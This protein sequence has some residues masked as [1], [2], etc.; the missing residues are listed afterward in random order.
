MG[1]TVWVLF[2]VYI[3]GFGISGVLFQLYGPADFSNI[4]TQGKYDVA[5]TE[6][7]TRVGENAVSV[8]YPADKRKEENATPFQKINWLNYEKDDK[9]IQGAKKAYEWFHQK[10]IRIQKFYQWRQLEIDVEKN[11]KVASDFRNGQKCLIPIV[12]SHGLEECRGTYSVMARELASHGYMV[13]LID[14]HDG[15]CVYTETSKNKSFDFDCSG[16]DIFS[17]Y[18]DMSAKVKLRELEMNQL[19]TQI[20]EHRFLQNTL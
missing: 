7:H 4:A 19:I 14:H 2:L 8:F 6:F 18:D 3:C 15:S 11:G 17:D 12:F 1:F 9:Q 13:F 10:E 20:I 16:N 5:M